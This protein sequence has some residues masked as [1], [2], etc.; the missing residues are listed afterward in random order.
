MWFPN[1]SDTNIAVQAQKTASS[2]KVRIKE[3]EE[4]YFPSSENK[5]AFPSYRD[6]EKRIPNEHIARVRNAFPTVFDLILKFV[7]LSFIKFSSCLYHT[8]VYNIMMFCTRFH[9]VTKLFITQETCINSH[10][11]YFD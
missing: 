7:E 11:L 2:L 4:L 9:S 5:G 6:F 3:E 8:S 10:T 1:R